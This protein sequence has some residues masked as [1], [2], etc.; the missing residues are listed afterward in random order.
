MHMPVE[1]WMPSDAMESI[2]PDN[3]SKDTTELGARILWRVEPLRLL[4]WT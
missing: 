3:P 2:G 4:I 1:Y